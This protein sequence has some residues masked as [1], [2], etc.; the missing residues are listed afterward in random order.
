MSFAFRRFSAGYLMPFHV[1]PKWKAKVLMC[2]VS[3]KTQVKT[4]HIVLSKANGDIVYG[5]LT[6]SQNA[7][8][9]N[10]TLTLSVLGRGG[11]KRGADGGTRGNVKKNK[12]EKIADILDTIETV[13]LKLQNN[14]LTQVVSNG[15]D[16]IEVAKNSAEQTPDLAVA[17]A[18]DHFMVVQLKRLQVALTS[19]NGEHKI[20]C[21]SKELFFQVVS[22]IDQI[23]RQLTMVQHSMTDVSHLICL[24]QFGTEDGSI[25]WTA[26]A[27][28]VGDV[29]E[30]KS[31]EV[32]RQST[33][34]A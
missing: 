33:A 8:C 18:L 29:L 34:S 27:T 7:I 22:N 20:Q 25:G 5:N 2:L 15:V 28:L 23:K 9:E 19:G 12:Q 31:K 17:N 14:P 10:Q 32:G 26:L 13:K 21:F 11:G 3:S 30:K 16:L 6:I 1:N 24:Q 4:S